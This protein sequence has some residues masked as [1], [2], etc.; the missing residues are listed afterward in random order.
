MIFP[1]TVAEVTEID[2]A[3]PEVRRL[4]IADLYA[5]EAAASR[6][7]VEPPSDE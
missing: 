5:W 4:T 2:W 3:S 1:T 7:V 6:R